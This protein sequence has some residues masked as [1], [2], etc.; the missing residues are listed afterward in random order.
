MRFY[1]LFSGTTV[2]P[3]DPGFATRAEAQVELR[4]AWLEE[5]ATAKRRGWKHAVCSH[6]KDSF[7]IRAG[8]DRQCPL[9]TRGAIVSF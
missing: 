2:H 3:S 9:W 4:N 7:E 6:T 5:L 8:R 1:L